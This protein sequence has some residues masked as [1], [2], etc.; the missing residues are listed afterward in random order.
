MLFSANRFSS[1]R[2]NLSAINQTLVFIP[3]ADL[4][5]QSAELRVGSKSARILEKHLW[6]NFNFQCYLLLEM[7]NYFLSQHV[8]IAARKRKREWKLS[9]CRMPLDLWE[10]SKTQTFLHSSSQ[11]K[12]HSSWCGQSLSVSG[13]ITREHFRLEK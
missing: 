5:L 11:E 7:S 6:I 8:N 10:S 4:S 12:I 3:Q 1:Y 9:F 2:K 13:T